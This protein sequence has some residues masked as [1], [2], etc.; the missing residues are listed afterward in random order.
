MKEAPLQGSMSAGCQN[1]TQLNQTNKTSY[2]SR[3]WDGGNKWAKR[4]R[5]A[6]NK[7]TTSVPL[8]APA[9]VSL[10]KVVVYRHCLNCDFDPHS[11]V[12]VKKKKRR[13]KEVKKKT[14]ISGHLNA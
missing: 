13:R 9:L 5:L 3:I 12:H 4:V 8:P 10:R 2:V 6:G 1:Y 7:R 14:L 11:Y